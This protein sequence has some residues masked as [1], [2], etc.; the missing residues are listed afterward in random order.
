M[1][2]K[3]LITLIAFGNLMLVLAG[4]Q[5]PYEANMASYILWLLISCSYTYGCLKIK[6]SPS[7][8]Y[9]FF[10]GN[11][12]LITFALLR[13]GWTF[14][15]GLA[16]AVAFLSLGTVVSAWT[17]YGL[18]KK[19]WKYEW[20]LMGTIFTDV[21]SF[22]PQNKQFFGP[23]EA[24]SMFLFMGLGLFALSM[25]YN[26]AFIEQTIQKIKAG[27]PLTRVIL[28]SGIATENLILLCVTMY[29]MS[30]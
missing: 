18:I 12:L 20:L 24:P 28:T 25:L 1:H 21:L 4:W 27:E 10:W 9:A 11:V 13:G 16:E 3:I 26:L 17:T 14:N 22:Y 5:N 2:Q 7:L 19:K 15:L 23:N 6:E 8:G 30:S 29:V